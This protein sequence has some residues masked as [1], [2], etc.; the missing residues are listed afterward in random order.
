MDPQRLNKGGS[1]YL[2]RPSLVHYVATREELMW[3]ADDLF[4]WVA[5]GEL[6]VHVGGR[7]PPRTPAGPRRTWRDA[8]RRANYC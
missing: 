2:T 4:G 7:Y 5:S 3:R 1:L 8:V 6:S